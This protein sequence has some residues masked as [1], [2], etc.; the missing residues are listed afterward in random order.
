MLSLS[1]IKQS[2]YL[3]PFL[4]IMDGMYCDINQEG[5]RE[6]IVWYKKSESPLF[7][8]NYLTAV[9][10]QPSTGILIYNW[11]I[12]GYQIKEFLKTDYIG[13]NRYLATMLEKYTGV[14]ILNIALE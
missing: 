5:S 10:Y 7:I 14:T 6:I 13:V 2:Y 8:N 4:D 1:K 3:P 12:I 11:S 9:H